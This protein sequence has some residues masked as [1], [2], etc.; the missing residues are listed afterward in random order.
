M[1]ADPSPDAGGDSTLATRLH[2]RLREDILAGHLPPGL[3]LKLR[4]LAARYGAGASPLREALSQLAAEGWAERLEH[5]GFR[6]AG[7]PAGELAGLI[8]SRILAEGA[9][10]QESIRRGGAAWEEGILLAEHRLA[11][12]D[13]SLDPQR[14]LANPA[15]EACHRAFHRALLAACEA[16]AL[17]AFCDRLREEAGRYRALANLRAYPGRHVAAEHAAIAQAALRRDAGAACA[18][19]AEHYERTG[20]LLGARISLEPGSG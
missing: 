6:V 18:L 16:P 3:K 7:A 13:R 9:A 8:R 19:L 2:R 17:L 12:L 4:D 1:P 10:L 14:F 15:W 20:Q 5:R 11:R